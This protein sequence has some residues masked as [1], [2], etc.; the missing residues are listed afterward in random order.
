MGA[1]RVRS[2]R[3]TALAATVLAVAPMAAVGLG[4]ATDAS[5]AAGCPAFSPTLARA[6]QA[7]F[8]GRVTGPTKTRRGGAMTVPVTVQS[9]YS[10]HARGAITV[11]M[12]AGRCQPGKLATGEDYVFLVSRAHGSTGRWMTTADARS[13][14]SYTETLNQRLH[15]LLDPTPPTV[16]FGTPLTGPPSSFARVAAPG[17]AML[18]VGLLGYV[19]VRRLGR[20]HA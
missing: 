5:Y 1:M 6:A 18:I 13:V 2:S 15:A 7:V 17:A 20:R 11:T 3:L 19:V 16:D 10:G 9:S 12:P 8:D 14:M 4:A